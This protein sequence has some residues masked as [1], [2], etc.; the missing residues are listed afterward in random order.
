MAEEFLANNKVNEK[1][2]YRRQ[3]FSKQLELL[4]V[5]NKDWRDRAEQEHHVILK[6]V[7]FDDV[8]PTRKNY[9]K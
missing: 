6:F 8:K 5:L 9:L 2:D 1:E 4:S 7:P 3:Y